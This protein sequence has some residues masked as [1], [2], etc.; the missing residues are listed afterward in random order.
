[1]ALR[2]AP[3]VEL[4]RR[5]ILNHTETGALIY[6]PFLGSGSTLIAADSV[7]RICFGV[8][9]SP[10]CVDIVVDRWQKI[11]GQQAVRDGDGVSFDERRASRDAEGDSGAARESA[12]EMVDVA[13]IL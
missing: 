4:M 12:G 3:Q 8:E 10:A 13:S 11:T 1:M 6:D 2:R 7:G 9:I 5:P